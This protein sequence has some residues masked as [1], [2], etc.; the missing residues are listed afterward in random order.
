MAHH[1]NFACNALFIKPLS[2]VVDPV[3][4]AIG[5]H[6]FMVAAARVTPLNLKIKQ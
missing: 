5:Q 2:L 6:A 4:L 1:R 3:T